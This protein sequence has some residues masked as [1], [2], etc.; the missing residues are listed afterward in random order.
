MSR[1]LTTL[2]SFSVVLMAAAFMIGLSI[3]DLY[4][5][6]TLET[7][8]WATVHRLTG[9]AA[10]LVVV[11]VESIIVTYFIGTSRWCKEVAETYGLDV[12]S[13]RASNRLKRR[14]FAVSLFGMMIV[15]G[16]IVL[17]AAADP[18]TGRPNTAAWTIY[19][20]VGSVVG[21][22][23]IVGTYFFAWQYIVEHHAIIRQMV[24]AV[25]Q[26]RRERGLDVAVDEPPSTAHEV[27]NLK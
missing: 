5:Q 19:H 6:P 1:I 7:R 24:D 10:A 14:A 22:T 25:A 8:H 3:G 18:A 23:L 15:L 9:L 4:H 27:T 16:I 12:A 13:V 26:I 2:A 17:G 20:L 11:L 21:I